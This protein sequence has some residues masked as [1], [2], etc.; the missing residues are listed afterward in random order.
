MTVTTLSVGSISG[1]RQLQCI[2]LKVALLVGVEIHVNV[3]FV[4]IIEPTGPNQGWRVKVD[5]E[6]HPV[7]EYEFDVLIGADGKRN[8]LQGKFWTVF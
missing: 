6:N 2:L 5:P 4:D 8:T 7:S 1:I 3:G